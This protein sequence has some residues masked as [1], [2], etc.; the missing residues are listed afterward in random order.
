MEKIY[1]KLDGGINIVE[2]DKK[3]AQA[4]ADMWNISRDDW[5]GDSNKKTER[6]VSNRYEQGS[7]LKTFLAVKDGEVLGMGDLTEYW[8]DVDATCIDLLNVPEKHQ[9]KGIGKE[10]VLL[11]LDET[12]KRGFPRME[13]FSWAGNTKAVPL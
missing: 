11:C 8:Y 5:G 1:K 10:I 2:Y 13:I 9:G 7:Y 6:V 3:Y 12:I 4:L